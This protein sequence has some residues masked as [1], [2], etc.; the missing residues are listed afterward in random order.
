[1]QAVEQHLKGLGADVVTT[2]EKLREA[3]GE[4]IGARLL[5]DALE[6][7]MLHC[8]KSP[9][10]QAACRAAARLQEAWMML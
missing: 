2:E 9:C 6:Q 1:M 7:A 8:T 3:F 10:F 4:Y 5:K